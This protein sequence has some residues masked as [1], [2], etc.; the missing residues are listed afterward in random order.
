MNSYSFVNEALQEAQKAFRLGEVPVGAVIVKDN[1]II[2]R[3]HN[4]TKTLNDSTAH[5]EL[6]VIQ[7]A[8]KVLKTP[9]LLDCSMYVTLEPCCM[10]A[11]A[12]SLSRLKR[13]YY[14]AYDPKGG[15]VDHG[16]VFF[17]Q[18]TCLH[19]PEVISGIE[20]THSSKLLKDFFNQ[21]R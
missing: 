13:L 12:I 4:L 15:A 6:L 3:A 19:A 5:A 10:C 2:A 9:Y 20:E 8:C 11:G 1:T 16:P 18:K 21:K 14:G 7:Q 17:S